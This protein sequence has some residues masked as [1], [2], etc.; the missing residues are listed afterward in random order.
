MMTFCIPNR[1]FILL[2]S[3]YSVMYRNTYHVTIFSLPSIFR[4]QSDDFISKDDFIWLKSLY[5][6]M[7][8]NTY[9]VSFVPTDSDSDFYIRLK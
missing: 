6:L 5:S 8:R 2:N 7:C 9:H 1:N 4:Y 3:L